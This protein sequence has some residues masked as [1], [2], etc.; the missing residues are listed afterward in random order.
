MLAKTK[1]PKVRVLIVD[2][3]RVVRIAAS[4]MFGEE[5]DVV[6]AV[7]GEDG[8][9][10]IQR[11]PD[12]Q[13]VF[14]DLVMPV[15]DGFELLKLIR[16][17]SKE[18]ISNLPVIV[19]T[20]ADNPEVAKQKA[21]SLGATDFI[22]KPFDAMAIRARAIAYARL[23]KANKVLQ[24]QTT[25]D[26]MTGLLNFKG[27]EQQLTKEMAFVSRHQANMTVVGVELDGFKDMFI[28][29]GRAG[30]E[31]IIKRV[32]NVLIDTVR[33][34]DTVARTGVAS[35]TITM[36]LAQTNNALELSDRICRKVEQLKARLDGKKMDITVS[37]GICALDANGTMDVETVLAATEY[38]LEQANAIGRSQMYQISL[39]DF[40]VL[41]ARMAGD[42]FSID[43][44]LKNIKEGNDGAVIPCLEVALERLAPFIDLLSIQQKQSL[45]S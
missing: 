28:R 1:P 41:Q 34:E 20:G 4:K 29:V 31:A 10:I 23:H 27:L 21:I 7:D 32:A 13:V 17:C 24:Q 26:V 44:L 15:M 36:P 12:I 18:S 6:L 16:T 38:A 22:A 45:L 25:L 43:E 33:K 2:D 5:F 30:A 35:F 19:A 9:D 37:S 14:T 11:D 8:W 40:Q 3:S 39:L 42:A